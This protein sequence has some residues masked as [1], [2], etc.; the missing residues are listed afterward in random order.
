[1]RRLIKQTIVTL[2]AHGWI[3]AQNTQ[4]AID[5]LGLRLA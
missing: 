1:M 3:S 2:Y 5:A 4:R